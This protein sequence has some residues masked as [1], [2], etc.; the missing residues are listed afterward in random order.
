[1]AFYK[2]LLIWILISL[3][4]AALCFA[5][6]K[7]YFCRVKGFE[8]RKSVTFVGCSLIFAVTVTYLFL[9]LVLCKAKLFTNTKDRFVDGIKNDIVSRTRDAFFEDA[10]DVIGEIVDSVMEHNQIVSAYGTDM[11]RAK[12]T[13]VMYA[14]KYSKNRTLKDSLENAFKLLNPTEIDGGAFEKFIQEYTLTECSRIVEKYSENI[15]ADYIQNSL[16]KPW[17]AP[18]VENVSMESFTGL[19]PD[20]AS[21]K[22]FN[23]AKDAFDKLFLRFS[24]MLAMVVSLVIILIIF[25]LREIEVEKEAGYERSYMFEYNSKSFE[26]M[27]TKWV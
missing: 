24:A 16:M 20:E 25:M 10:E 21:V 27:N 23:K 26:E 9:P 5:L 19:P 14:L 7:F 18:L 12:E 17:V 11:E 1:M 4:M 15:R 3:L 22:A 13:I 8:K 2:G 6:W